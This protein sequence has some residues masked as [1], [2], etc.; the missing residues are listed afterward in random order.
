MWD[1][2]LDQYLTHLVRMGSLT[3]TLPDGTQRQYGSGADDVPSVHLRLTGAN[4]VRRLVLN[5]HLAAG[6]AYMDQSLTIDGD[7]LHGFLEVILRNIAAGHDGTQSRLLSGWR[8]LTRGIRQRNHERR[9]RRNVAH[10]YDLS[11]G[12]YDLFLDEDRQYSCAY[13]KT[14]DD[15]LGTAQA[16]KKAHI[17]RKLCL[18]P[19]M[20][21]L[22][23]GCGWG[24]MG[25]TLARDH[26]A[27]VLGV[28]LSEEQLKIARQRAEAEGLSDRVTFELIDYRAVAGRFDRIVSVGMFEHV[29]APQYRTYFRK[30]RELLTD[31]GVALVH[32]IGRMTPPGSTNPWIAKYIFPG[33][34]IPAL[35]ETVAAIERENLWVTDVESWRLHYAYTLRHWHDRFMARRE[36]AVQLYDERFVRMWKFYLAASEQVFR[37][38]GQ[39][40]F[41]LQIT[42]QQDAVPLTRDYLYAD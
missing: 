20:R 30:L 5:P 6:E 8:D 14:P 42:R 19:G 9:A 4:T 24:G 22:D 26:G 25:L 34:Y 16:Q 31:N 37:F 41:Q 13:F 17:A 29:G 1:R 12:L 36:E 7:D 10:H 28:T 21:V 2:L 35:S 39:C 11:A 3:V 38:S 27:Q 33:G 18:T 32:S 40:V 15:S 23:I